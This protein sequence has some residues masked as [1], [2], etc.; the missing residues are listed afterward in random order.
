VRRTGT[1]RWTSFRKATTAATARF[2]P[3][4]GTWQ[5]RARTRKGGHQSGW[6]PA[7]PLP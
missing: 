1:S 7:L 6:S 4:K 2:D 5:A 3:G